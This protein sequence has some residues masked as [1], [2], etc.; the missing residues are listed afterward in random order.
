MLRNRICE[1][2]LTHRRSAPVVHEFDYPVWML[3]IDI[4]TLAR[5]DAVSRFLSVNHHNLIEL[6]ANDY[7]EGPGT[8][9]Q[10]VDRCVVRNGLSPTPGPILLLTTPRSWGH[11]FNPVSFFICLDSAGREIERVVAEVENTPWKERHAYVLSPPSSADAVQ[12]ESRKA[13]HVSPFNDMDQTYRWHFRLDEGH[14]RISM[15]VKGAGS[16]HFSATLD[17]V[18]TSLTAGGLRRGALSYPLQSARTL[19]RIYTQ[20]FRLWL[21]RTPVYV[22]PDKRVSHDH[23]RP[24]G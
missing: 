1:G 23:T 11:C 12:I 3:L 6:R 22:H 14:I 5:V 20:A 10:R 24:A 2:V 7:L 15:T 21:K 13:L 9:R 8:L 19:A 17:L 18:T 16:P 4:D